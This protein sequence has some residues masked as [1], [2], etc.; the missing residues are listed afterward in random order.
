MLPSVGPREP[1]GEL[2]HAKEAPLAAGDLGLR[3]PDDERR[4]GE[5]AQLGHHGRE[6][7]ARVAGHV[8]GDHDLRWH[9][10]GLLQ[11]DPASGVELAR[12]RSLVLEEGERRSAVCGSGHRKGGRRR[13]EGR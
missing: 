3:A 10:G 1:S 13:G 8:G 4:K 2:A 11:S 9:H 7:Q 6:R 5:G 12:G